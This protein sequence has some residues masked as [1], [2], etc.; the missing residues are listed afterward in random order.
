MWPK[1]SVIVP[2]RPGV[3][4]RAIAALH[5]ADYDPDRLEILIVEGDCPSR[6][7]NCGARQASGDI[8]YFL[9]DDSLIAPDALR[10]LALHYSTSDV[11]AVGGPSLTPDDEPLLSRCI[12]YALGTRLGAWTMRAR[13][14]PI[15]HCR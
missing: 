12:G 14:A 3:P 9:D 4:V 15:G 5:N 1:I 11:Q 8:L 13:Y 2:V 10:R 7:R 6:Q